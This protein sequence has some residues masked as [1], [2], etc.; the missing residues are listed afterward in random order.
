MDSQLDLGIL[1]EQ[2]LWGVSVWKLGAALVIIFLGFLSRRI[3][4]GI[5]N[6]I[7]KRRADKSKN[8]W[9]DDIARYVPRPLALV[10]QIILWHGAVLL[11]DLPTE[12]LDIRGYIYNGLSAAVAIGLVWVGFALIEVLGNGMSRRAAGTESKIDDLLVPMLRKS[13]KLFLAIIAGVW[14]IQNLGYSVTSIV[15]SLGIGGLALALAA[16]DTVSNFFGSVVVFTDKPFQVGDWVELDGVEGTIEEVGFRT[17]RI[18]QFDKAMVV[19]P[20][21]MFTTTPIRNYSQRSIRRIKMTVG[22]S[23]ETSSSKMQDFLAGARKLLEEHPVIDQNFHFVH[24]VE[25]AD[26]SLNVQ[27]YCFTSTSVW[28]EWLKARENLML[29]IMD[30][31]E[32]LG[33]EMAFPTRTVYLRD[34]KWGEEVTV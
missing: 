22:L 5:F 14:I 13:L 15:A 19:I 16:Q 12:P 20:N 28:V 33:L 3:I 25:F 9:D 21:K 26:S 24:F 7:I 34:E 31:V 30:L 6:G 29:Q 8:Q 2:I 1:S 17:T 11:L 27:F 23:Y 18:R 32:E 4:T 10:A